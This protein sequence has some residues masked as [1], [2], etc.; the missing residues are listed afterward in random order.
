[1]AA[2]HFDAC[3]LASAMLWASAELVGMRAAGE[4]IRHGDVV[5]KHVGVA[6]MISSRDK[7]AARNDQVRS[8]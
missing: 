5:I 3:S 2:L 4:A 7:M 6:P 1:M 8:S